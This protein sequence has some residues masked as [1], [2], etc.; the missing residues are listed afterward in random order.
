ML[1]I[2]NLEEAVARL[3]ARGGDAAQA[4]ARSIAEADATARRECRLRSELALAQQAAQRANA[5]AAELRCAS[6]ACAAAYTYLLLCRSIRQTFFPKQTFNPFLNNQH[7]LS[8]PVGQDSFA[9]R[10]WRACWPPMAMHCPA[11][12]AAS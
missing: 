9:Y 10:T 12:A 1:R 6:A 2:R 4:M 11:Q 7:I 5:Q 3:S 8:S